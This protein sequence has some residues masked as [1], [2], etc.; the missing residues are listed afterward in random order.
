LFPGTT[1]WQNP[2]EHTG[3]RSLSHIDAG[4]HHDDMAARL[5]VP[6]AEGGRSMVDLLGGRGADL[7]ELTGIGLPVPPGFT[8]TTDACREYLD[9]GR[10]PDSFE[11]QV[12]D[13][14]AVL[15]EATGR[16]FG[17]P[18]WPLLLSVGPSVPLPVPGLVETIPNVGLTDLVATSQSARLEGRLVWDRYRHLVQAY[19]RAVLGV[20]PRL[21]EATL[22]DVLRAE[23]VR[24]EAALD[25]R[26]LQYVVTEFR[27][28]LREESGAD[29]PQNPWAQLRTS[30]AAAFASWN[31]PRAKWYRAHEGIAD[32]VGT[33]VT[34]T[35]MVYG[36]TGWHS[37]RGVC[38]TR[39]PTTGE[40]RIHGQYLPNARGEELANGSRPT[41]SLE[42]LAS[43]EPAAYHQ[44]LDH[45]ATVEKRQPDARDVEFTL[46]DGRLWILG[47]HCG[48]RA[49]AALHTST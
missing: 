9:Q 22:A 44:L 21:F 35:R 12:R 36:N 26:A 38:T 29:L 7:S 43:L 3:R 19:G 32:T 49:P 40:P 15:E 47:T 14:V 39:E 31:S 11:E 24:D 42:R 18:H 23:A 17:D 45:L 16:R 28:T 34:V 41:I 1:V 25:M 27:R 4:A 2:T 46:E 6:F 10:L 30:I 37:G 20:D 13:A 5:L 48:E 8:V 33:A